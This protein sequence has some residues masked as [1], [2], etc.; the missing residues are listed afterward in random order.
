M[1]QHA[2]SDALLLI[3]VALRTPRGEGKVRR[4]LSKLAVDEMLAGIKEFAGAMLDLDGGP[5]NG[6]VAPPFELP[7]GLWPQQSLPDRGAGVKRLRRLF[8]QSRKLAS[9]IRTTWPALLADELV[10][11]EAINKRI[12]NVLQNLPMS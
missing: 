11:L 4:D 7:G 10:G 6:P 1:F 5:T 12:E 9:A 8:A 2:L 3:D